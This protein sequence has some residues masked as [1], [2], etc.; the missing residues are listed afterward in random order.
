MG[1]VLHES[2][3]GRLSC[4][5]PS[6]PAAFQFFAPAFEKTVTIRYRISVAV[7]VGAAAVVEV[8]EAA[9]VVEVAVAEPVVAAAL[10]VVVEAAAVVA[11]LGVAV[12]PVEVVAALEAAVVPVEVAVEA[13]EVEEVVVAE[14]EQQP[15]AT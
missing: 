7:V 5:E 12:E 11:A 1:G 9:V 14:V 13:A 8:V 6:R 3:T 15:L 2:R 4:R 10:E